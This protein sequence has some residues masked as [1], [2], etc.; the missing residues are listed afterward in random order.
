[1]SVSFPCKKISNGCVE[2]EALLST[3]E[4]LF[5]HTDPKTGVITEPGHALEGVSVKGKIV[6]FPGGKGSSVVQA[7]GMYK[8]DKAGSAPL[9]FIVQELD[10]VLVSSAIIMAMPMVCDLGEDFYQL[11]KTG[12][13]IRIDTQRLVVD[14]LDVQ[15]IGGEV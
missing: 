11:V 6:I 12:D 8:L 13:R 1:M 4:I 10:T 5:Y 14:R 15:K 2:G 7:D 9:G 3:D